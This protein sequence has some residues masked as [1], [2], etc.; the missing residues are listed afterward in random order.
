MP[1]AVVKHLEAGG[2]FRVGA[3]YGVAA[4]APDAHFY[5]VVTART[6][7]DNRWVAVRVEAD[8]A[9]PERLLA[10]SHQRFESR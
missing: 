1:T 5:G 3:I 10:P 9:E 2:P 7:I 6:P 4:G 8:A